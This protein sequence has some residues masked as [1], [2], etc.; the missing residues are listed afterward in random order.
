MN[1]NERQR[2]RRRADT[3]E[4]A[5][6]DL[7]KDKGRSNRERSR[8]LKLAK[9]KNVK[10]GSNPQTNEPDREDS[11]TMLDIKD[12]IAETLLNSFNEML[13]E[14]KN[15]AKIRDFMKKRLQ[16]AQTAEDEEHAGKEPTNPVPV[17]PIAKAHGHLNKAGQ[18][19]R[20]GLK[21]T[22]RYELEKSK[23]K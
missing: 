12:K 7:F 5:M 9:G 13:D 3:P 4:R 8:L 1:I 17:N 16:Q 11:Q 23:N 18:A 6:T 2:G 19:R 22:A 21:H 14:S 15:S 10:R 20:K